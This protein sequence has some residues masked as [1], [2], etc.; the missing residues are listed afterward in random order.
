MKQLFQAHETVEV[1]NIAMVRC[2][3]TTSYR[4]FSLPRQNN[5]FPMSE[6]GWLAPYIWYY[7]S[8]TISFR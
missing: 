5:G 1:L 4:V 8:P 7:I 6:L 2:F 3:R